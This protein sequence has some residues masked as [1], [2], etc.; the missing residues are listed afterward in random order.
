[1]LVRRLLL[2]A[3]SL[4]VAWLAVELWLGSRGP[5]GRLSG[6]GVEVLP[7]FEP[8][9]EQLERW[10][11]RL[12]RL[13]RQEADGGTGKSTPLI[14][15]SERYG[16]TF[17]KGTE[18]VLAGTQVS[19]NAI[20]ARGAREVGERPPPGALRVACYGESFTFC[21]EVD[22]G[23]DWPTQLEVS[24]DGALEVLNLGVIG[25]GTDQAL[26]RFRDS[27]GEL[28]SEVV[29]MGIMSENI[30]RNVNRLVSV[31]APDEQFPLVKP[32][33]LLESGELR[34]LPHP[35]TSKLELYEAA[36]GGSLGYDLAEHEWLAES[37]EGSGW[38]KLAEAVRVKRERAQRERWW[39]QWKEPDGE[40]YRV[41]VALLEAFHREALEAGARLAG[42]VVFPSIS[43]LSDPGRKLTT[44]HAA[45]DQRGIPYVDLYDLVSAR[46]ARGE[47][48]YGQSHLTPGANGEVARAVLAWLK[49][50]LDL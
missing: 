46:H 38:S 13:R 12:K 8:S 2:S 43:D 44:L 27:H 48:T 3:V 17:A 23:E 29:L 28:A 16:W 25:W 32:R 5:R 20:G 34:L 6:D 45:L 14:A 47:P 24:A 37:S 4:A 7:T 18:G 39:L 30:Q 19:L 35:Y 26:L 21:F 11:E 41:T 1:M 31:R 9:A 40:P 10:G 49:Q 42:V 50:E 33:F 15:F 36:V 22:D